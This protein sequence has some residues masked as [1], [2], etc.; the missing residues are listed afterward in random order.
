MNPINL[1]K[2]HE[3]IYFK[4]KKIFSVGEYF[5][6]GKEFLNTAQNF[7]FLFFQVND[8]FAVRL[9]SERIKKIIGFGLIF[10]VESNK[11]I[12]ETNIF[13]SDPVKIF[14]KFNHKIIKKILIKSHYDKNE[15]I[16]TSEYGY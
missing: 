11:I 6:K 13:F 15:K 3:N 8:I 16:G 2:R 7:Q 5:K 10:E 14:E 9:V 12:T 1:N 4:I